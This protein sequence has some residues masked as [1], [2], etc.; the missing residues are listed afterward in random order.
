MTEK[1]SGKAKS[2]WVDST[3]DT[4][5]SKIKPG[6]KVD[7]VVVGGG[8]AGINTAYMLKRSGKKVAL[9]EADRIVKDVTAA[10]TAKIS[11]HTIY[12]MQIA[13]IGKEKTKMYARANMDAVETVAEMVAE[14]DIDCDFRR[15]PCYFYTESE[16]QISLFEKESQLITE[17]ELPAAYTIDIPTS[18][19]AKAGL[20]YKNQA[21]FHPRKYLLAL[22]DKIEGNGSF[23][24]EKSRVLDVEG[25]FPFTVKT[26]QGSIV[27]D[28]VVIT[29]HYP[30]YDP[31]K[32]YQ[33]L[34]AN[35]TYIMA[36]YSNEEFPDATFVCIDP[37]HTYRST[38]SSKGK[39]IIIAGEHQVVGEKDTF[40]CY[41]ALEKYLKDKLKVKSIEYHWMNQD[42]ASPDSLPVIGETSQPGIYVATAFNGWGMTHGTTA[43]I[44][45]TD[46]I[47]GKKNPLKGI[48]DPLRFLNNNHPQEDYDEKIEL[49]EKFELGQ[50]TWPEDLDIPQLNP[51]ESV[52]IDDKFSVYKDENGKNHCLQAICPHMGCV[53]VW[54]NAEKSWDCPCHS[55]RF[56]HHGKVIHG[57]AV[58][59]LK[60]YH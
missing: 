4:N 8:V 40:K 44:L 27:A 28:N 54:N 31:D 26:D 56:D 55:A 9:I 7:V 30:I 32:L 6:L 38:P 50:V 2:F 36:Y 35:R 39:L 43:G 23:V 46:L 15:C 25:E 58:K 13:N 53:L 5:Y 60:N 48:F 29:T 3:P 16:N 22:A 12:T 14:L 10:T 20:I 19:D 51:G 57:P 41:S 24:F 59:D 42:N 47:N 37:F 18:P 45:L 52:I 21:E 34:K 17:L 33:H 1:I 11:S 49:A